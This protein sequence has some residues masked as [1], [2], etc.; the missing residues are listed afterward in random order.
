MVNNAWL[1]SL[2]ES[3]EKIINE[4]QEDIMPDEDKLFLLETYKDIIIA[5]IVKNN[6]I[7][8]RCLEVEE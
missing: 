1:K 8:K 5:E 4:I 2:I 7:L 3:N 6:A